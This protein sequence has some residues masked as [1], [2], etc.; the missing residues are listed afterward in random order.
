MRV[1]SSWNIRAA[2]AITSAGALCLLLTA[3]GGA[4][5]ITAPGG[6]AIPASRF[7]ERAGTDSLIAKASAAGGSTAKDPATGD[8]FMFDNSGN[9]WGYV[10]ASKAASGAPSTEAQARGVARRYAA[11][12][13]GASFQQYTESEPCMKGDQD[14]EQMEVHYVQYVDGVPTFNRLQLTVNKKSGDV[15]MALYRFGPVTVPLTPKV[16]SSEA[17][18]IA[19]DTFGMPVYMKDTV[20]LEVVDYPDS[21]GQHLVWH[22]GLHTGSA[23]FGSPA[24]GAAGVAAVDALTGQVLDWS[25]GGASQ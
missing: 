21:R 20:H 15:R 4:Q 12:V 14:P 1:P 23:S 8:L 22:V 24:P 6:M 5:P 10:R 17:E 7:S 16:P 9:V 19:A 2:V 13:L 11:G 18:S 25:V 3:S